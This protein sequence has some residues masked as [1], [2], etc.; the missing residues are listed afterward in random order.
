MN[1]VYIVR[2]DDAHPGQLQKGWDRIERALN[3]LGIKPIV[4][5]IP[6]NMD[7]SI[8]HEKGI[9]TAFWD[10][11]RKWQTNG[12]EIGVHGLHHLLRTGHRSILPI[13]D[14]SEFSGKTSEDQLSML[15]KAVDI[16]RSNGCVAKYFVAPAHGFDEQT[17]VALSHL[18][19][20]LIVS[21]GFGFRPF[22][23]D[24]IKFIPQQ[25]WRGRR[26]AFGIWTIC[27]HP[28]TMTEADFAHFIQFA[29]CNLASFSTP[30]H[31]LN[32]KE[33]TSLD[34]FWRLIHT[35]VFRIKKRRF[36]MTT[37]NE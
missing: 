28:S 3:E 23:Q 13:S 17:L 20:P 31:S 21:D 12:W 11:V 10:Q 24:G 25:L 8:S 36:Y 35:V 5:V 19:P 16:L 4:S 29:R 18:N 9:E 34:R 32:Y 22:I 7:K 37:A 1:P 33:Q 26:F 30:L 27:L 2:L 14:Y 15:T 6:Q